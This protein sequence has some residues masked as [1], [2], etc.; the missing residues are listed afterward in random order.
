MKDR[1]LKLLIA[2]LVYGSNGGAPAESPDVRDWLLD[3]A[4][5]IAADRRI[6]SWSVADRNKLSGRVWT[7]LDPRV[8]IVNYNR[9]PTSYARNVAVMDARRTGADLLMFVDSD[10]VPDNF[11]GVDSEAVAFW[12]AAFNFIYENWQK[13][14]LVV[15]APYMMGG[16]DCE[17][18]AISRWRSFVSS[19][20]HEFNHKLCAYSREEAVSMA[21]I[22]EC[23]ALAT[24]L[25]LYTTSAFKL[26]D[27][28]P[29]DMVEI[30]TKPLLKRID[31]GNRTFTATEVKD[32]IAYVVR[33]T[34]HL[35]KPWF[36]YE[37]ADIYECDKRSS[38][39][40]ANTRDISLAGLIRLGYN[41]VH[42][43]WSSWAS[44][45]KMRKVSKPHL[46]AAS[47]VAD[48]FHHAVE[49]GIEG[50]ERIIEVHCAGG[51]EE[52]WKDVVRVVG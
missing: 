10:M 48:R 1:Q 52:D 33:E 22:Q 26:V 51:E 24:G 25:I 16:G 14:P 6:E 5:K 17:R 35:S 3:T 15:G 13:G 31:A 30:I 47:D 20:E 40:V 21:G 34:R 4:A 2:P 32:L 39:D 8:A 27:P 18:V 37:Y 7:A 11:V 42:C 50:S 12:D 46:I 43:A 45:W 19:Y 36:Y 9:T 28:K 41:P 44:H 49:R 38:E 23:A 29:D